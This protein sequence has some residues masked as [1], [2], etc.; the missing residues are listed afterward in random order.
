M[1]GWIDRGKDEIDR[2]ID[3]I[4]KC[5]KYTKREKNEFND[6][7]KMMQSNPTRRDIQVGKLINSNRYRHLLPKSVEHINICIKMLKP[8]RT[9]MCNHSQIAKEIFTENYHLS[10]G[11]VYT[12]KRFFPHFEWNEEK[13]LVNEWTCLHN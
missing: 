11:D 6:F 10:T 2:V 8:V 13:Q 3:A 7:I 5:M 9:F 1:I 4:N 12:W